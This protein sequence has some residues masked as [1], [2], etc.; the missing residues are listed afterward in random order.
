MSGETSLQLTVFLFTL[1]LMPFGPLALDPDTHLML[2]LKLT[3]ITGY[4][5][6]LIFGLGIPL[7]RKFRAWR[8]RVSIH[9]H[10][11]C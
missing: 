9:E 6:A 3:I 7:A 8:R 4:S 2:L 10:A 1:I 5:Y 11:D